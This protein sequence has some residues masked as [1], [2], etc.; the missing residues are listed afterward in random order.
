MSSHNSKAATDAFEAAPF[1]DIA[2]GR[3]RP[4]QIAG[5][6]GLEILRAIPA[7]KLP[8]PSMARAMRQWIHN[9]EDGH[10]EFR[11]NPG[12]DYLNPMCFVHGGWVMT[13]LDSA[14]G[15]AV[16][17]T[18][19]AGQSYTSMGTEV[20]FIRPVLPDSGQLR[21]MADIVSRGRRSATAQARVE[22][23]SGR[24]YATGTTTCFIFAAGM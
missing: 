9:V 7:G 1:P 4:E 24:L 20:K 12:E 5:L 11:G 2:F 3:A 17:T 6:P 13:L 21:A 23:A 16:Q 19:A 15:C 18:L 10:A 14:L 8:A 22:D